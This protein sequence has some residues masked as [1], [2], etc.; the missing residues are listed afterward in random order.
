MSDVLYDATASMVRT[1][2]F[3]TVLVV[4]LTLLG[5]IL[6]V[7]RIP[8]L[9]TFGIPIA[10]ERIAGIVGILLVVL[11][12][13]RMLIWWIATKLDRLVIKEDEILWTHGLLNKQYTEINMGSVRAV[14]VSQGILRRIMNAGDV[15]IFTSGDVP[16]L[17]VKGLPNPSA[18]REHIKSEA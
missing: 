15:T 7:A 13:M 18:I 6:A 5:I 4:F 17:V 3:G 11:G 12:F 1:N 10:Y 2:P 14:R 16:E 8:L 9:E